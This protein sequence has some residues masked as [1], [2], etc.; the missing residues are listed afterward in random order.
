MDA[1]RL[2][3]EDTWSDKRWFVQQANHFRDQL[4]HMGDLTDVT[5]FRDAA[6]DMLN[7]AIA[8]H[9]RLTA[10]DTNIT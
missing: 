7:R 2:F 1:A 3:P 5:I 6:I 8:N 10:T 4:K 9:W